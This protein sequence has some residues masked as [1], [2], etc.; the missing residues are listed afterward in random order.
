MN[1]RD[2]FVDWCPVTKAI[3]FTTVIIVGILALT[4]ISLEII[5]GMQESSKQSF[6]LRMKQLEMRKVEE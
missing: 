3:V 1:A 2:F 5:S 6:Q 4:G